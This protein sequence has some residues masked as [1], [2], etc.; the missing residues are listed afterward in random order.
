[1]KR[2]LRCV[3]KVGTIGRTSWGGDALVPALAVLSVVGCL[4]S[5]A[6]EPRRSTVGYREPDW[7]ATR[8]AA[9]RPA[10]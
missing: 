8:A 1:M 2:V 4:S 6:Q 10:S 5:A 9:R 3:R 7:A